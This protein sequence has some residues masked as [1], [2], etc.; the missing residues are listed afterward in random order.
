LKR[1]VFFL[2]DFVSVE[3]N[4][5]RLLLRVE[6]KRDRWRKDL[7]LLRVEEFVKDEIR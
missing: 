5:R 1:I 3:T 6:T 2:F 4:L 7:F